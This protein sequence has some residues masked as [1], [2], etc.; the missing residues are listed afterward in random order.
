MSKYLVPEGFRDDVS[1]KVLIEHKY[2]NLIIDFFYNN[3]YDLIKTPLLEYENAHIGLNNLQITPNKKEKNLVIRDDITLQVSRLSSSRLINRKRPLK[4]CYYGEVVRKKGSM[5][6]PER[7]F[8]QVG[9]ECIGESSFLADVEMMQLA[10]SSLNLV[11]IKNITIQLS[12][13]LF[14][15]KLFS[16]VL[17]SK[18]LDKIKYLVTK[19]DLEGSLKLIDIRYHKIFKEVFSC[20]GSFD[21]IKLE[22][23]KIKNNKFFAKEVDKLLQII[24]SFKQVEN[25][26]SIYIDLL[27]VDENNYHDGVSYTFYAENVRGIIA[28]GGRYLISNLDKKES[29]TGFTCYMDTIIRASSETKLIK[30]IMVNSTIKKEIKDG[31][32]KKGYVVC[33]HFNKDD[34]IKKIAFENNCNFYFQNNTVKSL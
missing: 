30:K 6:R 32:I 18:H 21:Q 14:I 25:Q 8:L 15:E 20:I 24:A 23:D 22:L 12:S 28:R 4:V 13:K 1:D 9:A 2:K 5:L 19:K 26:A 29:A 33:T 27:E 10:Y 17:K 11:G 16:L 7:Q 3:G 34:Q 31:L